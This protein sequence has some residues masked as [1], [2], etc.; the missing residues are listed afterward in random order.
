MGQHLSRRISG[1]AGILILVMFF[2]PWIT[3]SCGS[4]DVSLSGL[5]IATGNI[6]DPS[7][8]RQAQTSGRSTADPIVFLVPLAGIVAIAGAVLLPLSQAKKA[9]FVAGIIGLAAQVIKYL[10][11]QS[12]LNQLSSQ[13]LGANVALRF[14]ISWWLT[15][16]A[17]IAVIY[18]GYQAN[19]DEQATTSIPPPS[20]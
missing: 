9:Y 15:A 2:F 1:P 12:D 3:V 14:E 7:I 8:Q 19:K 5:D 20:T 4:T 13:G 17:L 16:V 18:A 11:F 6:S 10:G